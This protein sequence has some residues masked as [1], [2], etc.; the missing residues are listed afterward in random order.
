MTISRSLRDVLYEKGIIGHVTVDLVSFPDPTDSDAHPL[1]WAVDLNLGLTDAA[2]CQCFFNFMMGGKMDKVTGD[3]MVEVA[4][5]QDEFEFTEMQEQKE[6]ADQALFEPRTFMFCKFLNHP[7]LSTIQYKMF[8]HLCRLDV[9]LSVKN[10]V[11]F[12]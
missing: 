2:A 11:D 10:L 3:Y 8:F 6:D 4:Q 1:F 5:D 7:Q 9:G 12:I